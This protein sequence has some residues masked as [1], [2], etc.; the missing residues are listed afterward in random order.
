[1]T[2][3][4]EILICHQFD[5]YSPYEVDTNII[6]STYRVAT[7]INSVCYTHITS[8]LIDDCPMNDQFATVRFPHIA[9]KLMLSILM[10]YLINTFLSVLLTYGN[11]PFLRSCQLCS[12]S[13]ISQNFMEPERSLPCSQQPSTHPYPEPDRFSPYHPIL[14]L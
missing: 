13:K 10:F 7:D 5:R 1:V 14:F 8:N 3:G 9:S 11:Q 6:I 4:N 12:H 2:E